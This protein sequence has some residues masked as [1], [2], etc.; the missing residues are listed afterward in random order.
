M[1][2]YL[3]PFGRRKPRFN[4]I[5]LV[6]AHNPQYFVVITHIFAMA[7]FGGLKSCLSS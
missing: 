2:P 7:G 3:F 5:S 1:I 6:I 4:F